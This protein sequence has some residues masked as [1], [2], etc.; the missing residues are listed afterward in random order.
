MRVIGNRLEN[1]QRDLSI[2]VADAA[3][4]ARIEKAYSVEHKF[5]A[6]LQVRTLSRV[7][8]DPMWGLF[9]DGEHLVESLP[10]AQ[11]EKSGAVLEKIKR[12][13][14][15]PR[16]VRRVGRGK[17]PIFYLGVF[18]NCWGHLL[19][20][21]TRFLWAVVEGKVPR[22]AT[23]A[24]SVLQ[25]AG[26]TAG[27]VAPNFAA[28]LK[29]LGIEKEQC[30]RITEPTEFDE[31]LFAS[32]AFR[33]DRYSIASHFYSREFAEIFEHIQ[34]SIVP[35]PKPPSRKI[36]L[37]RSHW[38]QNALDIGERQLEK[39][40][41]KFGGFEIVSPE[42]LTFCEMVK[43][44]SETKV[45]ATTEGSI[46]HNAV[47]LPR[48]AEIVLLEKFNFPNHYQPI[49]NEMKGLKVTYIEANWTRW[50]VCKGGVWLGPFCLEVTRHVGEYLGCPASWSIATRARYLWSIFWRKAY[51]AIRFSF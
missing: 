34:K 48:G 38:K 22:D 9:V 32:E 40:F 35:N 44:L 51:R 28:L 2:L 7:V 6:P 50:E 17:G 26:D 4:K 12:E 33:T 5:D 15:V 46:A 8:F 13:V 42:R 29:S 41:E 18:Y 27:E 11:S 30:I 3:L 1:M 14:K 43:L 45:L 47:F 24:Y 19:L 10:L 23:F 36:Y 20:D 31:I 25:K 37:S 49:V 39:A 21:G 16:S